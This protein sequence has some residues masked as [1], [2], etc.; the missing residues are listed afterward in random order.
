M[1]LEKIHTI[2]QHHARLPGDA[3]ALGADADLYMA[4]M[5]SHAS[6]AVM[7]ALETEFGVEFPDR[8]LRRDVFASMSAIAAAL[9]ELEVS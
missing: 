8:M 3:G 7:L 4:G 9:G 5:T 1:M 6:V 2:I